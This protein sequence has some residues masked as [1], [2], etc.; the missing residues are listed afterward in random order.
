MSE[1]NESLGVFITE[2]AT[3]SL[4]DIKFSIGPDGTVTGSVT[5][6]LGLNMCPLWFEA[7]F[8]QLEQCQ[9]ANQR[10]LA[11]HAV[12]ND[13]D[14][15]TALY[16]EALAG[17][18]AVSATCF[19]IDAYYA[20][21]KEHTTIEP[22]LIRVWRAKATPRYAQIA[23]VINRT[24]K[25]RNIG[26]QHLRKILKQGF[27][28]RDRAV[29]PPAAAAAPLRY[30]EINR[31]VEWRMVHFRFKNAALVAGANLS[32]VAQTVEL[33]RKHNTDGLQRF[34]EYTQTRVRDIVKRWE[35]RFGE[36]LPPDSSHSN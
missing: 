28:F 24:F 15:K 17:M 26:Q 25:T 10:V 7:A 27:D 4:T 12:A 32:A 20:L 23:Q 22:E 8:R 29:H 13:G 36:V 14:L 33:P 30:E 18:Q 21:L 34:C 31:S 9:E 19:A 35:P 6:T 16:D 2:G 11:A 3:F 1:A 5:S